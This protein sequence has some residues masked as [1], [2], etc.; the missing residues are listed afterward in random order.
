MTYLDYAEEMEIYKNDI[1]RS[2]QLAKSHKLIFKK[3]L[4]RA[5]EEQLTLD[6]TITVTVKH[7]IFILHEV[8]CSM[9]CLSIFK[10][11]K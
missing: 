3:W 8:V 1:Y 10:L 9:R 5:W 7:R 6:N 4:L 11:A 2:V